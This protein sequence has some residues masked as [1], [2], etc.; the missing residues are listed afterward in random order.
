MV[1]Y[2]TPDDGDIGVNAGL[3]QMDGGL[4]TAVFVSLFGGNEDDSGG[5]KDPNSW[6]GN[7]RQNRKYRSETQYLLNTTPPS[8]A[9]LKRIEDAA[10]RDLAW[11]LSDNVATDIRARV[12]IPAYNSVM[13]TINVDNDEFAYSENWSARA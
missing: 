9:N 11:M 12:T 6:W 5:E 7:I 3:V 4:Q 8:S 1:L 10:K 2:Q 13:I